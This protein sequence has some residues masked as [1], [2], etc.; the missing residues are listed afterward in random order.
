MC[1]CMYVCMG[2]I[3]FSS[4]L[5]IGVAYSAVVFVCRRTSTAIDYGVDIHREPSENA[6]SFR[7]NIHPSP[8]LFQII[9]S[10]FHP[11]CCLLVLTREVF[12]LQ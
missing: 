1:V 3:L 12:I 10:C 4:L 11:T 9:L 8:S 6:N 2:S 5:Y 7:K